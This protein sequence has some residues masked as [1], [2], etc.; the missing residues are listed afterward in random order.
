VPLA[1]EMESDEVI[2]TNSIPLEDY[3]NV[4][5][6]TLYQNII[7][8]FG[9]MLFPVQGSVLNFMNRTSHGDLLCKYEEIVSFNL[10]FFEESLILINNI[11]TNHPYSILLLIMQFS[12]R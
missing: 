9:N 5:H 12:Y 1:V 3:E 6:E 4:L 7:D 11:I 10:Y 2:G 8:N